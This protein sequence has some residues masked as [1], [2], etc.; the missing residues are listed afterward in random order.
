MRIVFEKV[1]ESET[2]SFACSEVATA[3]F[4]CPYHVHPEVEI[5]HIRQG[6]G[7]LV[8]GD[9]VGRFAA[10]DLMVLGGGLPHMLNSDAGAPDLDTGTRL[11]YIQF[12][13]E[14][15]GERFW[16]LRE[17]QP[18]SRLLN[19]SRR[20]LRFENA[21]AALDRLDRLWE[22]PGI[23][24]LLQLVELLD[25]LAAGERVPLASVGYTPAVT[26]RDSERL[27]RAVQYINRH[28]TETVTLDA[29]A[30]EA[31]MS[32]QAFGRLFRKLVGMPCIDYVIALRVSLACRHLLETD[33]TV[34]AIAFLVGFNNLSNFNRQFLRL[35]GMTPGAYRRSAAETLEQR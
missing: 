16:Q 25:D 11:R 28:L 8:V 6:Q 30:V 5:L 2:S 22:A 17:M 7:H 18:A 12:R 31:G 10:G 33:Q 34:A 1:R 23:G 20:G 21:T 19:H 13:P 35:K 4:S 3:A 15:F 24:H 26:H 9:H 14:D 32:I 29:V 27:D